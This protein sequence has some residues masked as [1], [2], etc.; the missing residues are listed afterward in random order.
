MA[1]VERD[2][3]LGVPK[4]CNF[5]KIVYPGGAGCWRS[6]VGGGQRN[7]SDQARLDLSVGHALPWQEALG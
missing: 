4:G 3:P 2:V 1:T 5:L 7:R 6:E